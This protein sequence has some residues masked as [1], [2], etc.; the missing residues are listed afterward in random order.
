MSEIVNKIKSHSALTPAAIA[1]ETEHEKISYQRLCELI[2][3]LSDWIR[4]ERCTTLAYQLDNGW[5]WAAL[6]LAGLSTSVNLV[7]I[8][9]F[10][11]PIQ[12]AHTLEDAKVDLFVTDSGFIPTRETAQAR[13]WASVDFPL[14]SIM[15]TTRPAK[16]EAG[17][18]TPSISCY[19]RDIAVA[20]FTDTKITY[21]S[22]STGSPKG[23]VL[24]KAT[25]ETVSASIVSAMSTI[26][27]S[28]HLCVLPLATL[29]EN[30]AG[31]YAPLLKGV[32]VQIP[33]LDNVGLTGA[34]L[35]IE[36]FTR[37]INEAQ[38]DSVIVVPQLLTAVVALTQFEILNSKSLKMIAV[39]GGRV[40]E[41]LL[42][43]AAAS[44]L[45]VYQGYGLSECCSV[46][47]LN[48][49]ADN[50]QGSV[51]KPLPHASLRIN[52]GG[53]I[54]ANGS[55]FSGYLGDPPMTNGWYKTGDLGHIDSDGFVYV[56]G[57]IKNLFITSFGRNVNPEWI[58]SALTQQ[59]EILQALVYGENQPHNLALVWLRFPEADTDMT[60]VLAKANAELPDY[61]RVHSWI[62]VN[63]EPPADLA[64]PNGRLKRDS[65]LCHYQSMIEAHYTKNCSSPSA[66]IAEVSEHP[67]TLHRG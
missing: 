65:A 37:T 32:T 43:S 53:E 4:S 48:L 23:V 7:P 45:P 59:P 49:P 5:L 29:L 56:T 42:E 36:K 64:T 38:A 30:I 31:L 3:S 26:D 21:T 55:I 20:D 12:T 10:F 15:F 47:T 67:T 62:I 39:G 46:L 50:K 18:S 27:I 6:D 24:G 52:D 61:A 2:E 19:K 8:P 35:D 40:S 33:S 22:G 63:G 51:G 66:F 17:D 28:K 58:E 16:S 11:S 60:R 34:S 13:S 44:G 14:T 41:H 57:R 1:I 25:V 9:G 54:E